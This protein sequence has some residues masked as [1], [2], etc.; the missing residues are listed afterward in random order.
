MT[1]R[2]EK[3][4]INTKTNTNTN[5]NKTKQ[6]TD[7]NDIFCEKCDSI[8]DISKKPNRQPDTLDS[9]VETPKDVSSDEESNDDKK[10]NN[11]DY[12]HILK[13]MEKGETLTNDELQTIDVKELV[14]NEYYKKLAGKGDIKKK[15]IDMIE[16]AGNSD[17]NTHAYMVCKNCSFSKKMESGYKVV[18]KNPEGS[19]TDSEIINEVMLRN[20]IHFGPHPRSREFDCPNKS[21]PTHKSGT[22]TEA[23]FVRKHQNTHETIYVC[24]ECLTV[25]MN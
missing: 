9:D 5:T 12:E 16:D 23:I 1:E 3:T 4:N 13:K 10:E 25:M 17:E 21:C 7:V 24:T 6:E 8:L 14:K 18:T 11:V 15:L 19:N 22:P 2:K 20:R